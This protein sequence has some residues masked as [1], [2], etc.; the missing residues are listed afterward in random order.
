MASREFVEDGT[1]GPF[2]PYRSFAT[3]AIRADVESPHGQEDE[4]GSWPPSIS[5][6]CVTRERHIPVSSLPLGCLRRRWRRKRRLRRRGGG[7]GP[8]TS[9]PKGHGEE[10]QRG[11]DRPRGERGIVG[12]DRA[13]GERGVGGHLSRARPRHVPPRS[14][15]RAPPAPI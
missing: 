14:G 8:P 11:D 15:A 12:Q 3:R 10:D 4:F 7:L 5:Q 13:R 2:H 6:D 1:G 9:P